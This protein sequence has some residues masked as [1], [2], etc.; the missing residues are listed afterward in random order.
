VNESDRA[1]L[2]DGAA[3]LGIPLTKEQLDQF[4]HYGDLLTEWN[5][6][7]NL[8]R[9]PPKEYIILHFLDSL[10]A[11]AAVSF[12]DSIRVIDVGTGAGLPGI[13]LKIAFPYLDVTLLDSTRKR[14][15]FVDSAIESLGLSG[16]RTLHA[17]ADQAS[18]LPAHR[19]RYDVSVARA[20]A[21][22]PVLAA[23]LIPFVRVGGVA[24]ALKST[25]VDQEVADS[26]EVI[27][28]LGCDKPAQHRVSLPGTEIE[29]SI[30]VMKK[31]RH[32]LAKRS[33]G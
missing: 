1:V 7:L 23:W 29:R 10:A 17:R 9:V 16:I 12:S 8:T 14:L 33:T 6:R 15:A 21:K 28:R 11:A 13:P 20:V 2:L 31:R 5:Q 25:R 30:I 26:A 27:Q 32:T 22:L 3:E 19:E 18:R 4:A 24:V